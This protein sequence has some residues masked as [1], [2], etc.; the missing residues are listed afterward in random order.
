[1]RAICRA[2]LPVRLLLH[3]IGG[4]SWRGHESGLLLGPTLGLVAAS[5]S[6]RRWGRL[7]LFDIG[8]RARSGQQLTSSLCMNL[9][10]DSKRP[11]TS[12]QRDF[13][14]WKGGYAERQPI[15]GSD[16]CTP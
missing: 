13:D 7:A 14:R 16:P 12:A 15:A 8:P 1:M 4:S 9:A 3:Q 6:F 2:A 5:Q 10:P 11:S